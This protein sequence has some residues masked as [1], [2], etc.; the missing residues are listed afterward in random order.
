MAT[1][2]LEAISSL[3]RLQMLSLQCPL[4]AA[5]H[6]CIPRQN[7][8]CFPCL[9]ELSL[10]SS[11]T[12][13]DS[14]TFFLQN[15]P[16]SRLEDLAVF[17]SSTGR[18]VLPQFLKAIPYVV[19]H[20]TLKRISI[21]D[22]HGMETETAD[23]SALQPL[24]AFRN[25]EKL[26][27]SLSGHPFRID[28]SAIEAFADAWPQLQSI[29]LHVDYTANPTIAAFSHLVRQCPELEEIAIE[30]DASSPETAL[31]RPHE[32]SNSRIRWLDV[33]RSRLKD[34]MLVAAYLAALFPV[35][36]DI[37]VD[38]VSHWA[39]LWKEVEAALLRF[40]VT[41][42]SSASARAASSR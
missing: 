17:A 30:F 23:F 31:P 8:L 36:R 29:S 5:L 9:R 32:F 16:P 24:L 38:S 15:R 11:R 27:L 3:P 22:L 7:R 12:T 2:V 35:L 10:L 14:Y 20:R 6:G 37:R 1:E 34:P 41:S 26:S 25:I 33:Q 18:S 42:A 19:S 28:D 13:F 21:C 40:S 39:K 4:E